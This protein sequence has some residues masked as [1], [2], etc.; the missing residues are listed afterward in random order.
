MKSKTRVLTLVAAALVLV[1]MSAPA[2]APSKM[3]IRAKAA[4]KPSA[5]AYH[6]EW[7]KL[8]EDHITWTRVVIMAVANALPGTTAYTQRLLQNVPD[9]MAAFAPY[10]PASDLSE[11]GD[12]IT[13]H[14]TIAKQILDTV[15][16]GGDPT[17][18][19]AAWRQNG[20][21][22]AAKMAEMN[23]TYWPFEMGDQMWQ[24]H[25]TATLEEAT[26]HF[27]G[28]FAAEIAAYDR[29]HV[30]ALEMADFFSNGVIRTSAQFKQENC[31]P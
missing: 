21:D 6:D 20:T 3:S 25:L 30:L 19:I 28:D 16:A 31:I 2:K 23:P 4:A 9:M 17:A 11:L 18:L 5:V 14:L 8:W 26:A 24:E 29:V 7:R 27:A 1:A 12:L 15:K 22:I 13:E 10:F